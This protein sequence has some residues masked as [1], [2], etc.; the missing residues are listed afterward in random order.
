MKKYLF[1]YSKTLLLFSKN[2]INY[3]LIYKKKII[4]KY[5]FIIIINFYKKA[6][7]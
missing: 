5:F 2:I 6:I 1:I 4:I 7:E 3:S